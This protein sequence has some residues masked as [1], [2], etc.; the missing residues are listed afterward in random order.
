VLPVK[1]ILFPTDFS[2]NARYAMDHVRD[3]A[4]A[5][6]ARVHLLHVVETTLQAAD[7]SWSV[8]APEMDEKMRK[9][10]TERLQALAAELELPETTVQIAVAKG[11]PS[12]EISRYAEQNGV[13]LIIMA[14]HGH[15]GLSHFL[16]GSVTERV[17]RKAPCPVLTVRSRGD[18]G[19]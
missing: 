4:R 17:V 18:E 5:F 13:D 9:G 1:T 11:H 14:T 8:A 2:A 7:L 3:F 19:D 15:T 10:A 16:L 6:N 12:L